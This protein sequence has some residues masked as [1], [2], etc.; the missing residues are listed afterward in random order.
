MINKYNVS[1][2]FRW[3]AAALGEEKRLETSAGT[4]AY[5]AALPD[6]RITAVPDSYTYIAEDN[7]AGM[8]DALTA[9]LAPVAG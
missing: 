2:Y 6:A 5:A 3:R 1:S 4:L 8:A 9:M 7:P